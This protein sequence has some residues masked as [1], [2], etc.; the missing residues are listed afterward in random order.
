MD[1]R[2]AANGLNGDREGFQEEGDDSG[3]EV[4]DDDEKGE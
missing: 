1:E 2:R 3:D 4:E